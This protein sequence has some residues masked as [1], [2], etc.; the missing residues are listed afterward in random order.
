MCMYQE[1]FGKYVLELNMSNYVSDCF[2]LSFGKLMD[3]F[4]GKLNEDIELLF[5]IVLS[6]HICKAQ[7]RRV[8]EYKAFDYSMIVV[9][10]VAHLQELLKCAT[11]WG[12]PPSLS[13][14][15]LKNSRSSW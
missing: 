2:N 9:S 13:C 8:F 11:I 10:I 3:H 1:G 12:F 15:L 7:N 4:N 5:G 14:K 6:W